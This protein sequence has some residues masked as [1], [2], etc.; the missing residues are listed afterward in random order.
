MPAKK[1]GT[2]SRKSGGKAG[3]SRS[4]KGT[5]PSAA[6]S[7]SEVA[8]RDL[9]LCS[10][11]S[12][13][14]YSWNVNG[15]RAVTKKGFFDWLDSHAVDIFCLQETRARTD[16]VRADSAAR[17]LLESPEFAWYWS[18]AEK[19]GYSG[20]ASFARC[21]PIS[22]QIGFTDDPPERNFNSEGRVVIT[23]FPWF[24]LWNVYFPNGGR[25]P[26]RVEYKL[27]FYEHCL[28]LWEKTRRAGKKLIICGDYNTA[29]KEI[30]LARPKE[31]QKT[32]GFLPEERAFLDKMSG[33]GY[34]DIF[35]RFDP[36]PG[37]YTYW[38]QITR[39]RE[40]NTGWRIDYF[41]VTEETVPM[42]ERAWIEADVMGSDHCP[43]GI[44]VR[45]A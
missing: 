7:L 35:R 12:V 14:I 2:P 32:S 23:E 31:N 21:R 20:T 13:N 40:R 42:I 29:H 41:W 33:L 18:N 19:G 28:N 34:V 1:A 44:E 5:S 36:S 24:V 15:I 16:Q 17:R 27:A 30:D 8:D 45:I 25:G 4:S 22:H 10:G 3:P 39:A 9:P 43:V 26:E 11:T 37:R 6:P 38:D